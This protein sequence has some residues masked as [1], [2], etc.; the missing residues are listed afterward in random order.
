MIKREIRLA[1]IIILIYS[2]MLP[3]GDA[4]NGEDEVINNI[5]L[6][7]LW[8]KQLDDLIDNPRNF[9]KFVNEDLT[10][11][12]LTKSG[13][14]LHDHYYI[15]GNNG[16]QLF[17]V[18]AID[19]PF[20]ESKSFREWS[21]FVIA[22]KQGKLDQLNFYWDELMSYK[23]NFIGAIQKYYNYTTDDLENRF[24]LYKLNQ[25]GKRIKMWEVDL[26]CI[27]IAPR[28][29]DKVCPN[30]CLVSESGNVVIW[31]DPFSRSSL[32]YLTIYNSKGKKV[33]ERSCWLGEEGV[34]PGVCLS[35][36]KFFSKDKVWVN[37]WDKT[38]GNNVL[39]DMN[40]GKIL[41]E[42]FEDWKVNPVFHSQHLGYINPDRGILFQNRS[43]SK[44]VFFFKDGEIN[45]LSNVPYFNDSMRDGIRESKYFE[46]TRGL[47]IVLIKKENLR[48]EK[49]VTFNIEK[50]KN[51]W[52]I[53]NNKEGYEFGGLAVSRNGELTVVGRVECTT[54]EKG[55]FWENRDKYDYENLF[56]NRNGEII[57]T[58]NFKAR[59]FLSD[60]AKKILFI[61]T[62]NKHM[63][64]YKIAKQH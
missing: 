52:V 51:T 33:W 29:Y 8:E 37:L 17:Q 50:E 43:N 6:N 40:T 48:G 7:L 18:S 55:D 2:I 19:K 54:E 34:D 15:F 59:F 16:E 1:S 47:S 25:T 45:K 27:G 42:R 23:G 9:S 41:W 49:I 36:L 12:T 21:E 10:R 39:I 13:E 61:D 56:I 44:P 30:K 32:T 26:P 35:G 64:L 60:D 5:E 58:T 28:K 24:V 63:R 31:A 3:F 53:E 20:P 4:V 38:V 62:V 14:T 46:D 57:K 22:K 11:I